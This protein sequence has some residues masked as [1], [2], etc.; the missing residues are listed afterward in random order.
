MEP[1]SSAARYSVCIP[2]SLV[3]ANAVRS[4]SCWPAYAYMLLP[5]V[6]TQSFRGHAP[7]LVCLPD[8]ADAEEE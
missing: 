1:P 6:Y 7:G 4:Y 8:I 2:S 3:Y 5:L